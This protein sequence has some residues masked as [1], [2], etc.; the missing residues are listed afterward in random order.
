MPDIDELVI[1]NPYKLP[2]EHWKFNF[3]LREYERKSTRRS[4]G[5]IIASPSSNDVDDPGVF[6][7]I[8]LVNL[9]RERV[10]RWRHNGYP[11]VT[12]VTKQLLEFWNDH[13]SR[14]TPFF[15]CQLEAIETLI[16]ILEA[17]KHEKQGIYIPLDG[18]EFVRYCS[19]M[20]T[21][22][23]KTV[24]MAMLIAWQ[25]LNKVA[26]P[27]DTRF[28]KY[29]LVVAPGL[30]VKKRLQ[31]LWP[32]DHSQSYYNK[33][34]VVPDSLYTKLR[35]GKVI[36]ENWHSL[37][38]KNDK[39][40]RVTKLGPM[41]PAAFAKKILL[42]D[43]DHIVVINDEAHHAWRSTTGSPKTKLNLDQKFE[44]ERATL[45]M[46]GLDIIHR[47][48]SIT[49]CF[50]FTATPFIPNKKINDDILFKWIVSDFSLNDAIESGLVK[51]P[52]MPTGD[53]GKSLK[54]DDRSKYYH[55]YSHDTVKHN[56][57]SKT[58]PNTPLPDIIRN[59]YMLLGH[60]WEKTRQSWKKSKIPPVMITVCN[61]V[62][63]AARISH[64]FKNDLFKFRELSAD[65]AIC[66][67]DTSVLKEEAVENQSELSPLREKINTVG[68][69][70]KP[71]EQLKNIIAVQML[72]EGWDAKNVTQIMGLRAFT[73]QLLCEQVVGR[74]LRRSSYEINP[75]TG[76]FDEEHV[77]ILGVPFSFL[78]HEITPGT[79]KPDKPKIPVA[80]DP[81]NQA[82]EI[83]WPNV[84]RIETIITPH[85]NIDWSQVPPLVLHSK[86]DATVHVA[87]MLD[88]K[89]DIRRASEITLRNSFKNLRMQTIIFHTVR[90]IY[91]SL[92]IPGWIGNKTYLF[93]QLITL[94][95]KFI[96]KDKIQ[97]LHLI[98][99][100]EI[101]KNLVIMFNMNAVVNHIHE[102]IRVS[103]Q[104]SKKLIFGETKLKSTSDM[105]LWYWNKGFM[106]VKKSHVNPATHEN[107]WEK[108]A[109]TEFER[110]ERVISWVKNHRLGFKIK[111]VYNGI[112]H[113]YIPDY[114]IK[115]ENGL[116]LILEIKGQRS[117]Q[118]CKKHDALI[119]WVETV[120]NDK[121]FGQW[122]CDVAYT[123]DSIP[124]ILKKF[125]ELTIT[126][127]RL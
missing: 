80:C 43:S 79:P 90:D 98:D 61:N 4:A 35:K 23:G 5:Y 25:I 10:D 107:N 48:R 120:N 27:T 114:I 15:F 72:S 103:H 99:N 126:T 14:E 85:L 28:S 92:L 111:Y 60:D 30:T 41:S 52:R 62:H 104:S 78:P 117:E 69:I 29:I 86:V 74:G 22:T 16:W 101:R 49:A 63:T 91:N 106:F 95:E 121:R 68:Q 47:A 112:I 116:H 32:P 42:H 77:N 13:L 8:P 7:P 89:P 3:E 97:F 9:I 6:Q 96:S 21:G 55:I 1:C 109:A 51:T 102:H 17:P 75:D 18:G 34:S 56:L 2:R 123:L 81:Y 37:I 44:I 24:V 84:V 110:N 76:L 64:F 67:I 36:I 20:A 125:S 58:S 46:E 71:G 100:L 88:K 122:A 33:F 83:I 124:I 94:V 119:E 54:V 53:D 31:V 118:N 19:K 73:S 26:Y 38:P 50:D 127:T 108:H 12:S 66:R 40:H 59:A 11:G 113:S 39:P 82:H 87:P 57:N 45:W 93:S 105:Q 65:D 70:G 115:L